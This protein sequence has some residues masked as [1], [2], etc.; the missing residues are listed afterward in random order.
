[1][2]STP[3]RGQAAASDPGP[4]AAGPGKTGTHW[5]RRGQRPKALPD[6]HRKR[7]NGRKWEAG[8]HGSFP[9]RS[10]SEHKRG[11]NRAT[12]PI[13]SGARE[14]LPAT[15]SPVMGGDQLG[16][17]PEVLFEAQLEGLANGADD[18]LS[19]PFG[20]LQNVAGWGH[21]RGCR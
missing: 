21:S 16:R 17:V 4:T 18:V 8:A 15:R 10:H 5:H 20:T 1:M 19:E 14:L 13:G 3:S 6:G 12:I 9:S 11:K 2:K 7:E